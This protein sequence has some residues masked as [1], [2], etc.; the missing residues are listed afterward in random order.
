MIT[1]KNDSKIISQLM[2]EFLNEEIDYLKLQTLLFEFRSLLLS[3]TDLDLN[4]LEDRKDLEFDN[5]I[6]LCTTFAALCAQDITRTRQFV[7]GIYKAI[8][9]RQKIQKEPIHIFYAGTG[10]FATLILPIL[11]RF[12][13][14]ELVLTLLDVNER[15][16][17]YLDKVLDQL[18]IR[19]YVREIICDDATKYQF[20]EDQ[21]IDILISETMQQGLVKEQQVPIM[22]NLVS[23]LPED[24]IVIPNN[25][26]LDLALK[27]SSANFIMSGQNHLMYQKLER[28]WDFDSKF[29]RSTSKNQKEFE[30]CKNTSL[31]NVEEGW[32]KLVT[33]TSIQVYKDEWILIDE[34]GLTIP[35]LLHE[36]NEKENKTE[37]SIRYIIQKEPDFEVELN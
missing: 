34:S 32:D 25:I 4:D 9:D 10:P 12:S 11:S 31:R 22:I 35:K 15:T 13:S 23:Q 17:S 36:L 29:M 8:K 6:A 26:R 5:G 19:H 7:R 21:K 3:I 16:L 33:L 14:E 20:C 2:D 28:L 30:L 37:V 24:S 1:P 18:S 27:N